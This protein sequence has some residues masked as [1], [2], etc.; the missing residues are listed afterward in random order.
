MFAG[1][2]KNGVEMRS[3]YG[4]KSA[5]VE[6]TWY[7]VADR[8]RLALFEKVVGIDG[9]HCELRKEVLIPEGRKKTHELV[10][11]RPGR[12][13]DSRDSTHHGQSGGS[14]HSYGQT[15]NPIE[16]ITEKT[17]REAAAII[18]SKRFGAEGARLVIVAEPRMVGHLRA[19]FANFSP[20]I[21]TTYVEKDFS[22]LT[23]RQL[24]ARLKFYSQ[25][26]L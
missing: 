17:A 4:M 3:T 7:L 9:I 6:K 8:G 23:M 15:V 1:K 20:R 14:R 12:S 26:T 21:K 11:D 16:V 24:Q 18:E 5:T 13:F 10:S 22:W 2:T 19:N 25:S